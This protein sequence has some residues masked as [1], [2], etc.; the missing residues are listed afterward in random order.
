[1]EFHN[2]YFLLTSNCNLQCRYCFQEDG[3]HTSEKTAV[4]RQ[5]VDAFIAFARQ[6]TFHHVELFGG[7]PLLYKDMLL[8]TVRVLREQLPQT[9]IGLVTNGTLLDEDIMAM[10]EANPVNV[11]LSLDGRPERHDSFRG[12]YERISRWFPRLLATGRTNVALQAGRVEGL[13][14][15]VAFV[16]GLGFRNVFINVIQNYGWYSAAELTAFEAEYEKAVQGM[17]AGKG[18]LGCAAGLYEMLEKSDVD[19]RCGITGSGLTCD[20]RGRFYPCHRAPE[21]GDGFCFGDVYGGIRED[22]M[23]RLR[24][25]IY[26]A[27]RRSASC[28]Q[29]PLLSFCPVS[30]HQQH[31]D[32]AGEWPEG[33]C[34]ILMTKIKLVAKYHYEIE[35]YLKDNESKRAAAEVC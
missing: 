34:D 24:A 31:G 29:Y 32:F 23:R 11:L 15:Q 5:V 10:L 22:D 35:A 13:A 19:Y 33:F 26:D 4:T 17:L 2:V 3:Y 21:L 7:E 27:S 14:D 25:E 16:W 1:M 12:G 8:Y 6:N 9:S 28:G 30:V 18:H 20:W